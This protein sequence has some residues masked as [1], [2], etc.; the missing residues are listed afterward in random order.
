MPAPAPCTGRGIGAL[1]HGAVIGGLA[2]AYPCHH[3]HMCSCQGHWRIH[4]LLWLTLMLRSAVFLPSDPA[5]G[6]IFGSLYETGAQLGVFGL[7]VA[8]LGGGLVITGVFNFAPR[9]EDFLTP[10]A[11]VK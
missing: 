8:F 1:W 4:L 2:R 11:S 5:V 3:S 9:K 6:A 10:F 7:S